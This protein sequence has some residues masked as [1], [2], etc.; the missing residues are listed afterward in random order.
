MKKDNKNNQELSFY[1][2]FIKIKNVE[3]IPKKKGCYI[4]RIIDGVKM[5]QKYRFEKNILSNRVIY[6]GLGGKEKTKATIKSRFS[7]HKQDSGTPSSSFRRS[8]SAALMVEKQ[9][10]PFL[11]DKDK[12]DHEKKE[13]T[14]I[15]DFI[16]HNCECRFIRL[17]DNINFDTAEKLEEYLIEDLKPTLNC[18][19]N[20]D[21][22]HNEYFDDISEL[23]REQRK[24]ASSI[25]YMIMIQ[26]LFWLKLI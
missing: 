1:N 16:K 8:I 25:K 7:I 11:N 13:R 14:I 26:I 5:H 6:V 21:K 20:H 10:K 18:K 19:D 15:T 22:E 3:D 9:L 23:R 2:D 17:K 4:I 24:E 12:I